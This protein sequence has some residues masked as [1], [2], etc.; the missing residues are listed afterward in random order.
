MSPLSEYIKTSQE[1]TGL[2]S[3]V[4]RQLM[5]AGIALIWIFKSNDSNLISLPKELLFPTGFLVIALI[6]DLFQYIV[7]SLIWYC[8]YRY[9]EKKGTKFKDEINSP[10]Y[11]TYIINSFFYLKILAVLVAY[12]YLAEFILINLKFI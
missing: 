7:G 4:S 11:F 1:F 9:H 3:T 10:I 5:F 12:V 2:A 6:L 8:F